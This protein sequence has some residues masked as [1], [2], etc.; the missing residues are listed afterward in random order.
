M[1]MII[2]PFRGNAEAA[3]LPPAQPK[4]NRSP[5]PIR[6]RTF[7]KSVVL[8]GS[9]VGLWAMRVF[10]AA[11]EAWADTGGYQIFTNGDTG[12]CLSGGYAANDNCTGCNR[13]PCD[14]QICCVSSSSLP[15]Y[16]YMKSQYH[17]YD[18]F[19]LRPNECIND[20]GYDGWEWEYDGSCGNCLHWSNFRCHDGWEAIGGS[21]FKTICRWKLGC[22]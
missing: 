12:P 8:G 11:R 17:G 16:R 21:W 20:T 5:R 18:A 2:A 22:A 9:V 4:G 10:P 19:G 13:V 15:H 7:M 1:E 6:R 3:D 14:S